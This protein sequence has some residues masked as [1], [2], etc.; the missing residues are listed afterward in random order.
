MRLRVRRV[1]DPPFLRTESAKAGQ[2]RDLALLE[3]G[4][5]DGARFVAGLAGVGIEGGK[6]ELIHRAEVHREENLA[7]LHGG[8]DERDGFGGSATGANRDAVAGGEAEAG[9]GEQGAVD[10]AA[11]EVLD[12]A[13]GEGPQEGDEEEEERTKGEE[14]ERRGG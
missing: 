1:F 13:E 9:G 6:G 5:S 3:A 10:A 2:V 8:R 12:E 4:D 7:G 11:G 14:K